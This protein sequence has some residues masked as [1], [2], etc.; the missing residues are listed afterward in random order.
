[1]SVVIFILILSFLVLIHELG[2]FI[3]ARRAGIVVEEFGIGYPP[4]AIKLFTWRG[5]VFTLNWIPFGGF[6][7]MA[8]EESSEEAAAELAEKKT[9]KQKQAD[10]GQFYQASNVNKLAV[11]L[12]G[13]AVN[14]IFGVI[15][16]TIVFSKMGIPVQ[17]TAARIGAIAPESPAAIAAI[18]TGVEVIAFQPPESEAI[19]VSTSA[20]LIDLIAAHKG[21]TVA[22]TTTGACQE[23]EC[24]ELAQTYS[25]YLRTA[26]ETPAGQGSLGIVFESVVFQHYPW[27]QMPFRSAWYGLTQAVYLGQ[28]IVVAL[29][30]LGK[31]I[32]SSGSVPDELAGP[33]GIVHQA[34]S[35][36]IFSDGPLALLSFAGMLSVNLAI[37]N[38]LPIPPLDGGRAVLILLTPFLSKQR[39]LK[40]EYYANYSGYVL[41]LGLIIFITVRD[42]TK[43]FFG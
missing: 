33:V 4:K 40:I 38:V 36:G 1:M 8:G 35:S 29:G 19:A 14:F 18:P 6:V 2:H 26:E 12:A 25:V 31:D 9:V 21:K 39:R 34:Q 5:T 27:W 11:I 43:V 42:I 41:L 28:Q 7:R 13:A 17:L 37:M 22:L 24:Q 10:S 32:I 15:A 30:T 3:V 20:Q 16:F 23:T